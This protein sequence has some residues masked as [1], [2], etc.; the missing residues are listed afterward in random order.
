MDHI[1]CFYNKTLVHLNVTVILVRILDNKL[2]RYEVL[3]FEVNVWV[4]AVWP[5]RL[6]P[7]CLTNW[8][9][10]WD[11][12]DIVYIIKID[13]KAFLRSKSLD[14]HKWSLT[15]M[16]SYINN[17]IIKYFMIF[18]SIL[19]L[20]IIKF[21]GLCLRLRILINEYIIVHT[22]CPPIKQPRC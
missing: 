20:I 18:K 3:M 5:L 2:L 14:N 15:T 12:L 10:H 16:I 4:T 8:N 1:N 21:Y 11:I 13:I 7:T 19:I 22:E 17:L 6:R 9:I